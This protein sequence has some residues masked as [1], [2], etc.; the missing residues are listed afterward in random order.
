MMGWELMGGVGWAGILAGAFWAASMVLVVWLVREIFPAPRGSMTDS[1]RKILDR[2]YAAGEIS[3][4][5]YEQSRR[6]L[7]PN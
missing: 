6:T 4:A 7:G 5:E 2:R 1:A 3:A